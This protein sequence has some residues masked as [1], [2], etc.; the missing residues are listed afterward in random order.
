LGRAAAGL[1]RGRSARSAGPAWPIGQPAE[2][3]DLSLEFVDP[4]GLLPDDAEQMLYQGRLADEVA[5]K[6]LV[7]KGLRAEVAERLELLRQVHEGRGTCRES[8]DSGDCAEMPSSS[9]GAA[10]R[11]SPGLLRGYTQDLGDRE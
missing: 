8:S 10:P 1:S 6:L 3:S 9:N 5:N 2:T 4:L 11:P 7:G